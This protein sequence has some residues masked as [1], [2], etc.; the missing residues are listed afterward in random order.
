MC[1][2][3]HVFVFYFLWS[4]VDFNTSLISMGDPRA[5]HARTRQ[6]NIALVGNTEQGSEEQ[7]REK[8][9]WGRASGPNSLAERQEENEKENV[10]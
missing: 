4:L 3:L 5:W 1:A 9:S 6:N 10:V 8:S 7:G 2:A